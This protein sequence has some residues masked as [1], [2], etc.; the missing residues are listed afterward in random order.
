MAW[1]GI[2]EAKN[3]CSR[4]PNRLQHDRPIDSQPDRL[5]DELTD[6]ETVVPAAA[7]LVRCSARSDTAVQS[8]FSISDESTKV[9]RLST[10]SVTAGGPTYQGSVGIPPAPASRNG[11]R[12]SIPVAWGRNMQ[13]S[14]SSPILPVLFCLTWLTKHDTCGTTVTQTR[15]QVPVR[16][17]R[18]AWT[19]TSTSK[20][21]NASNPISFP[22]FPPAGPLDPRSSTPV[23]SQ[24]SPGSPSLGT[25]GLPL[26][27]PSVD[28]TTI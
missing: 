6:A 23:P 12:Q 19:R 7:I 20:S 1:Q 9:Q 26:P 21:P 3:S 22:S 15:A 25:A 18:L 24:P 14:D 2:R 13:S 27:L 5:D 16:Q 10:V 11:T 8:L 17:G 4:N 28:T